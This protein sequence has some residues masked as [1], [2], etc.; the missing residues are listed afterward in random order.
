VFAQL[1]IAMAPSQAVINTCASVETPVKAGG[2]SDMATE[3]T[4]RIEKKQ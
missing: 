4:S 2:T 3:E 1:L